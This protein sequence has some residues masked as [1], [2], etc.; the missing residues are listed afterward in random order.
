MPAEPQPTG[1]PHY[2]LCIP[3]DHDPTADHLRHEEGKPNR[4]DE[5]ESDGLTAS[6]REGKRLVSDGVSASRDPFQGDRR[7]RNPHEC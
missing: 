6:L 5:Q 3:E 1:T 4:K 2:P 7:V